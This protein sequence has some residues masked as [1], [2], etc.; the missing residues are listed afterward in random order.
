MNDTIL[1]ATR[2][3]VGGVAENKRSVTR[4][5]KPR[6]NWTARKQHLFLTKLAETGNVTISLAETG[7]SSGSVYRLR[8]RSAS[9]RAA[10]DEA[11]DST[12]ANVEAMLL[13]RALRGRR[14]IWRDGQIVE[15]FVECSDGLALSLLAQH[16]KRPVDGSPDVSAEAAAG[17]DDPARLRERFTT[18][19]K[20]LARAAGW[21]E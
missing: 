19:L 3:I 9:F 17:R 1:A 4:S 10:W 6:N 2:Q 7:M 5:V 13:D 18:K 11:F 12:Y 20:R 14:R 21:Q 15:E 8:N 16:R